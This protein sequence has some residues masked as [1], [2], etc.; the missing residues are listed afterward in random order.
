MESLCHY[1]CDLL[2]DLTGK[3]D[4]PWRTAS[5]VNSVAYAYKCDICD[6]V[7]CLSVKKWIYPI[8]AIRDIKLLYALQHE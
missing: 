5:M 4:V 2:T 1:P 8:L 6:T 3:N 7:S